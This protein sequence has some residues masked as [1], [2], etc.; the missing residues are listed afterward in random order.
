MPAPDGASAP[1]P[2]PFGWLVLLF[3]V[4]GL[5]ALAYQVILAR[6]VHLVVGATAYATSALLVAFMVGMSLG[7]AAGGALADRSRHPLRVY[8][9][10]EAGIGL[11]CLLFPAA[12]PLLER[13]YLALAPPLDGP[14]ALRNAVRFL[15][16]AA[17]FVLPAFL[18]G[19]TTPAF[20]RALAAGQADV[21][22]RLAR[23]YGLNTLGAAVGAF[24]TA[25]LLVPKLGLVGSMT[26][27]SLLNFGV[28]AI[29]WRLSRPREAEPGPSEAGPP[30]AALEGEPA[31]AA[32]PGGGPTAAGVAGGPLAALLVVAALSGFLSFGLEI[33][34]THLL[35]ILLGNSVYAFG[36]MLGSL[37]LG[38][39]L[40]ARLA[41]D[42]AESP[43]RSRLWVG[44]ALALA[45]AVVVGT[46]SLWDEVPALFLLFARS[47]PSFLLMEGVR[48]AVAVGLMI[49]PTTLIGLA[50]PLVLRSAA[51]EGERFGRSVGR[52]FAVNTLGAVAGAL[53]AS[54]LLLPALGSLDSLRLLG[55]ALLAVGGLALLVLGPPR[56]GRWLAAGAAAGAAAGWAMPVYWDF[57]SLNVGAAIYLG[58][59]AGEGGRILFRREHPTGGLTTVIERRGVKTLLTN[60]KFEGDD[61]EEVPIQHRLANIPTLFTAERERA[62][63][64]GLGTGVTLASVAAHGFRDV[65]CAE[66]SEAIVD[67]ARTQFAHVNG[68]VL[69]RPEVR[70]AREDGRSVLLESPERYDV[71]SVEITT[72]WFAG[73]GAIYSDGFYRLVSRR[74]RRHGVL[75]QWFPIHHL[76]AR[77]LYL[78]VNT[79]R[80]VFPHVSVWTHRHQG[81]VVASNEPLAVDLESVRA[82]LARPAM[83]PYL[84]ELRSGSPLELLSDLVVVGKDTDRFLNTMASLLLTTRDLVSTDT[85]PVIEYETPKDIL[86]NFSYFRNRATFQRFRGAGLPPFRGT[87]TA[88]ERALAEVAA[89]RGWGDPRAL[90]RLARAWAEHGEL[91]GAASRWLL[92]E[93][94]REDV[95]G[96]GTPVDPVEELRGTVGPLTRLLSSAATGTTCE[97]SPP[98]LSGE[99]LVPLSL[100]EVTGETVPPTRPD[101]IVDGI[102][103]ADWADG[104]RVR[105][106]GRPPVVELLLDPPRRLASVHVAVR[107]LDGA[108]VRTRLLGRDR[109]GRW[110]PL[111]SG[112]QA[113]DLACLD[114]RRYRL[115]SPVEWTA[116]RLELQGESLSSRIALH[117]V[118]AVEPPRGAGP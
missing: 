30:A 85:W 26:L 102:A 54:Y 109:E 114:T 75:L 35:A 116:L 111:A 108:L 27:A 15:L 29:A 9:L 103:T 99:G 16:G 49:F 23:I 20:A 66:L 51:R 71:V 83:A 62:L 91:S 92:D 90:A 33:V 7:S 78:V 72:I 100:G 80:S 13:L 24:L 115:S 32:A 21:G 44:L 50:F 87:P 31:P 38:L 95:A 106:D 60:G 112:G 76:S 10:A 55:V 65:V 22:R 57:N 4:S 94:T 11:Y 39:A 2:R 98:F 88:A 1:A 104:W 64:V 117:E 69:S 86:D 81:F 42:F 77:N 113:S 12:F 45:G 118:F 73:S 28:A 41:E 6:Y 40:G 18:M 58:S 79:V 105:P 97:E 101:A 107:P 68:G 74:L 19:T 53:A 25:Y 3:F 93:L 70:L 34:W 52:V 46:L 14:L 59:S 8:A 63:V 43:E 89:A 47:S 56:S 82:D 48:L 96:S 67:A 36:L 37:L 110:H 84:R 17:A 5:S 61:S